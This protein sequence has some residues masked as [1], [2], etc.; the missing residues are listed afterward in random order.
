[1]LHL[2][3]P[4][5]L[6]ALHALYED[7]KLHV[8]RW[9]HLSDLGRLLVALATLLRAP[10]YLDHYLRDLGPGCLPPA[11]AGLLAQSVAPSAA[12]NVSLAQPADMHRA[13]LRLLQRPHVLF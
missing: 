11:A 5:A 6:E 9:H 2:K 4:Q 3:L 12:E 7:Y 1:M 13:L 10:L 8:L